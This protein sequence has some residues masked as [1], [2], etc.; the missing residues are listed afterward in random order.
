MNTQKLIFSSSQRGFASV[1]IVLLVGL[2]LGGSVLGTAYYLKSSQKSLVASHALTNA[3]SGAWTGV[4]V[5]R[6]YLNNLDGATILSLNDNSLK[7]KIQD[8]RELNVNHI[9]ATQTSTSPEVYQVSAQV[10][11]LST[12]SEAS[13]T[14]QIVYEIRPDATSTPG[15]DNPGGST[16]FPEAMNFYGDLT[17]QGGIHLSNGDSERAVINVA[18]NFTANSISGIKTLNVI[19]DVNI[20]GAGIQGLENIYTNG[21]V[22]LNGSGSVKLISAKGKVTT[23][24]SWSADDIYADQDVTIDSSSTF[25]TI[26]TKASLLVSGN[27]NITTATVGQK[28]TVNNGSIQKALA[29]SDIKYNVWNA[30]NSAKSGGN[31][32]CVGES[33][34]N[35]SSLSAVNFTKCKQPSSKIES[36]SAGTKVAFPTGAIATVTMTGK[37]LVNAHVYEQQANYVFDVDSQNRIVVYVRHVEGIEDGQYFL[38]KNGNLWG[39]LCRTVESSSNKKET[40]PT[41]TSESVT[42]LQHKNLT[43]FKKI[44]SYASGT[45]S[46][47]DY[48]KEITSIAPGVILFKGNINIPQGKYSNTIIATGNINYGGSVTLDA[49]NYAGANTTCLANYFKMPTN[50]CRSKVELIPASI[51]NIALLSG[52]CSNSSSLEACEANYLGGN[53][54]LGGSATIQGNIIA[55]N[56]LITGGSTNIKGSILAAAHTSDKQSS[57]GGSTNID[58]DG[59][60]QDD[61]TIIIPGG[62]GD[63]EEAPSS[64]SSEK[65]KIRWARYI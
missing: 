4:E 55:G 43:W 37:P 65:A 10:Q 1:L 21:N 23:G 36:L 24:G 32:T 34:D 57:L 27:S 14:I 56:K 62:D 49:P 44:I 7:L 54:T 31:F 3:Q 50:L 53:I 28:I 6:Q 63:D 25:K 59:K 40:D 52:S 39:A 47:E 45:W 26:D 42:N 17:A 20:N 61:T 2:A 9:A 19:G 35:F 48:Q 29:N 18:G 60:D 12:R 30:L 38:A 64:G 46:L 15:E 16:S 41:C 58:F 13:S 8:G 11:N 51:G 22:N 5:L 33:W